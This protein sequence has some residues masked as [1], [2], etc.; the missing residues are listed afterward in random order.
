MVP[1][2]EEEE[3]LDYLR[4]MKIS[5]DSDLSTFA[6][7]SFYSLTQPRFGKAKDNKVITQFIPFSFLIPETTKKKYTFLLKFILDFEF[8]SS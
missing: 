6:E 2:R 3:D 1:G 8:I 4:F 5:Y 7:L